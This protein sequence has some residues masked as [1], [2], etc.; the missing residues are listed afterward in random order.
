M[1]CYQLS[2]LLFDLKMNEPR[3]KQ[4]QTDFESV[5]REYD[6]TSEEKMRS[7]PE[8]PESCASWACT[9]CFASTSNVSILSLGITFT[10]NK[11]RGII[12]HW[13]LRQRASNSGFL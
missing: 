4:A 9:A 3:V 8:I 1:S 12:F 7:E 2:R 13:Q 10:G 5:M 11:N 6:L